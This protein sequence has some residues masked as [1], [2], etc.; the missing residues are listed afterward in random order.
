M[1]ANFGRVADPADNGRY[2]TSMRR[3]R[4]DVEVGGRVARSLVGF[5]EIGEGDKSPAL[6]R[7][8]VAKYFDTGF[9][10]A[11]LSPSGHPSYRVP[12]VVPTPFEITSTNAVRAH[13]GVKNVSPPRWISEVVVRHRSDPAL[14]F[15]VLNTHYIAGAYNGDQHRDRRPYWDAHHDL[16]VERIKHYHRKGLPVI[17]TGDVN[18]RGMGK[19]HRLEQQAI[20]TGIDQIRWIPGTNGTELRLRR[21]QT[22]R[23]DDREGARRAR[24]GHAG[25]ARPDARVL[26]DAGHGVPVLTWVMPTPR[27][28]SP[29][30]RLV[31]LGAL[32]APLAVAV[33]P[34][35]PAQT[36]APVRLPPARV[37]GRPDRER[38]GDPCRSRG[39]VTSCARPASQVVEEPGWLTRTAS[40]TLNPD[41]RAVAPHRRAQQRQQPAPRAERRASTAAP[42]CPGPLCHAL[43]DYNGVFHLVSANYANHAGT[44][45]PA[46]RSRPAAATRC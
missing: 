16:H 8:L 25:A 13:A 41:R 27:P 15:A 19:L 3:V 26:P 10:R 4:R 31:L 30:R 46:A 2:E 20:G 11:F 22:D 9:Q 18:R 43:V 23:H 21:T 28:P 38:G 1:T 44:A 37:P 42:T 17:W 45:A 6:E 7:K 33:L 34:A 5:Q 35:A 14:R 39:S 29:S 32:S 36:A 40:G 12:V 24:G